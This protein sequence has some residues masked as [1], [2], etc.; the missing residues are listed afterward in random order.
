M[1]PRQRQYT[2]SIWARI[3]FG[4]G[5]LLI[6]AAVLRGAF[7]QP[8]ATDDPRQ[9]FLEG[10]QAFQRRDFVAVISP[11]QLAVAKLPDAGDYALYYLAAAQ[12]QTGDLA[13]AAANYRRLEDS[14]PASIFANDAGVEYAHAELKL[15][16][17]AT[18]EAAA[19][20]VALRSGESSDAQNARLLVAEAAYAQGDFATAYTEAQ[21]LRERFPR[22]GAD[23]AA[24]ALAVTIR[25]AH[26]SIVTLPPLEFHYREAT[27]L[28]RE[29]SFASARSEIGKALALG[30]S[31][32][33]R[34]DLYW[35][36]AEASRADA[37]AARAALLRY[38]EIAPTGTH[39]AT[40]MNTL[41]HLYWRVDDTAHARYYFDRVAGR[42]SADSGVASEAIFESA[43]TY[44]DDGDRSA[45][46]RGYLRLIARYPSSDAAASAR[47]RAP[48]MLYMDGNYAEAA[49]EF[50]AAARRAGD[51]DW[52]MYAYWQARSLEQSGRRASA[53]ELLR[54]V[55]ADKRSNYYPALALRRLRFDTT[56]HA[57]EPP[58][59]IALAP[60]PSADGSVG[61][62]LA[63]IAFFR[64]IGLKELEAGELRAISDSPSPALRR[65]I[66][67]EAQAA[68]A[69]YEAI[70]MANKMVASGQLSSAA[71]ERIR[72]PQG[73]WDLIH[74]ASA[75]G[76]L[77]PW[78]VAALI[79]QESLY[80]PHARSGSDARGLMQLM[81]D[82]A[83]HWAAAAG[84]TTAQLDLFDP[85]VSVR[86]GTVYLKALLDMFGNDPMK[87]V[88][89]YN[90][91]EHAVAGWSAKYP[92]DDDQWVENIGYKETREY[93]KKVI[94]GR[95]EYRLLYEPD[96]AATLTRA[97]ASQPAKTLQRLSANLND[98]HH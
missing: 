36:N 66:L 67:D 57:V 49:N 97:T 8:V 24:R 90:G 50:A 75:R 59:V 13:N 19:R 92:G 7:A 20:R 28:V 3:A 35:L 15:G 74:S 27:L 81:H 88:A 1:S 31:A 2:L 47:F 48:F 86:I 65:F 98:P 58:P 68:G 5:A 43:R 16:D 4:G 52:A 14:Y 46:R 33:M 93:V 83:V 45:A 79:R 17:P 41:A 12:A 10:Y 54:T 73:F 40:A 9:A 78:L 32:P 34:V 56:S 87:A 62:H 82:T 26:P 63:R 70:Q 30:P 84:M 55:A 39:V 61:F 91:G 64:A 77:D 53:T 42:F 89:A 72:Y 25:S 95:R 69:W 60:L 85:K 44:E 23:P 37:T 71:T 96:Y 94:G 21:S 29:D 80:N 11:M 51:L 18:A 6:G 22:G 76:Q 38:L